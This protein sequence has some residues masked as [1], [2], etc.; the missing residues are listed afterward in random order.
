[1]RAELPEDLSTL[2]ESELRQISATADE[3]R[4]AALIELRGR[5]ARELASVREQRFAA[6]SPGTRKIAEAV[7]ETLPKRIG[8][9]AMA[10]TAIIVAVGA[11]D[12]APT[13]KETLGT[14]QRVIRDLDDVMKAAPDAAVPKDST[15]VDRALGL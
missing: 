3:I 11:V 12:C 9:V 6:M 4:I 15:A 5:N 7:A 13:T 10:I 14:T 1:M 8:L 2:S